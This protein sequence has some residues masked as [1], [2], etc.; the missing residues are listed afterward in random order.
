MCILVIPNVLTAGNVIDLLG[1]ASAILVMTEL[2]AND[3]NVLTI[4]TTVVFA[5]LNAFLPEMQVWSMINLGM[6]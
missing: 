2:H 5:I 3:T 4:V 1:S 6:R